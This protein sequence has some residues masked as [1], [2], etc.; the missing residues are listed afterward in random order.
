MPTEP[1][2]NDLKTD[3]RWLLIEHIVSTVPFQKSPRL[4][5]LLRYLADRSIHGHS[6]ELT[7]HHIGS[8]IFG[9]PKDYNPVE[10]SSVRVQVRQLRLKLHEYFDGEGRA[11][12]LIVEIPKG[13]YTP[14]FRHV[15]PSPPPSL[16]ETPA[17][18]SSQVDQ[19]SPHRKSLQF[20][21][22]A[23]T[24]SLVV[25]SL[26]LWHKMN[27]MQKAVA[28]PPWPL[29][30][31]FSNATQIHIVLADVSYGMLRIMEEKP[32]SLEEYLSP[33]FDQTFMPRDM[34]E[35]E[36]RLFLYLSNSLLT[37]YADAVTVNAIAGAAKAKADHL[38]VR[39]A[40]DLDTRDLQNGNYIFV[41]SPGSNPWVSLF[42]DKLNFIE[43]EG[44]VGQSVK[45]FE[46]K[47]P[48][49]GESSTYQDLQVTGSDG[50]DYA[51][52]ALLPSEG[53]SGKVLIL[54]GLHEE[55]TEAAGLFLSDA[56]DCL[57]LGKALGI[58]RDDA[59]SVYFEA[60][61][62]T[63]VIAGASRDTTIVATRII[64]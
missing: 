50:D 10:D 42:Q 20:I 9:K 48:L 43:H 1:I 36:K 2:E 27:V 15:Q 59:Q 62:R 11:E 23:I 41:G 16:P 57:Q 5:E 6:A 33:D 18:E 29:S 26:V 17:N 8:T 32:G 40:R 4:R 13:A 49:A 37:S 54:Q 25:V 3:E 24:A 63:H 12:T 35:R 21:S 64:H 31:V 14:V 38:I 52:I 7:E 55:G 44:V 45:Y 28:N 30:E 47:H 19:P 53:G 56:K 60:L 51:T 22:W 39:S 34:S 46:N 58:Q 61:I